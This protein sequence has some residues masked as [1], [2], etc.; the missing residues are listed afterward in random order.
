MIDGKSLDA[1]RSHRTTNKTG[2]D[3]FV[4]LITT[5]DNDLSYLFDVSA[6]L[7]GKNHDDAVNVGVLHDDIQRLGI[8]IAG[9]ISEHVNRIMDVGGRRQDG[10]ELSLIHISEPTR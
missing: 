10:L 2:Y 3:W 5:I 1:N 8:T 9:G 6:S 4:R 7:R